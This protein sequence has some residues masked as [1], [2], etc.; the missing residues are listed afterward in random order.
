MSKKLLLGKEKKVKTEDK[1]SFT[2]AAAEAA[3]ADKK[4]FDF[5]GKEYP[6]EITKEKAK[7]IVNE[8]YEFFMEQVEPFD[9][10]PLQDYVDNQ[11]VYGNMGELASDDNGNP[12]LFG[13]IVQTTIKFLQAVGIT[14]PSET[15]LRSKFAA[16]Q[17][18]PEIRELQKELGVGVDGK[19]GPD[20][21]SAM[22]SNYKNLK[23]KNPPKSWSELLADFNRQV[24][25]VKTFFGNIPKNW[26]EGLANSIGMISSGSG[27]AGRMMG[28]LQSLGLVAIPLSVVL[29]VG[30]AGRFGWRRYVRSREKRQLARMF[31]NDNDIYKILEAKAQEAVKDIP[32][33]DEILLK[34]II[35]KTE[36][37]EKRFGI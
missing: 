33:F 35:R 2:Y 37:A 16:R 4:T 14:P 15:V 9:I 13:K 29:A 24:S 30:L 12:A 8:E 20:T 26:L 31:A 27:V 23:F 22:I 21:F 18:V 36:A 17:A 32:D 1:S 3:L 19:V 11:A 25:T 6:V 7:E 28:I 10:S 34:E 5:D